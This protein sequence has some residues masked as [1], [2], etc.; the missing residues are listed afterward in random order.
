MA[1][2]ITTP[3]DEASFDIRSFNAELRVLLVGVEDHRRALLTDQLS[4][5]YA[6]CLDSASTLKEALTKLASPQSNYEVVVVN[7]YFDSTIAPHHG[8]AIPL[9]REISH[10]IAPPQVVVYT[11]IQNGGMSETLEAGAFRY[12]HP[13]I[14]P[15]ELLS[16]IREAA[17]YHRLSSAE[18]ERGTSRMRARRGP[19]RRG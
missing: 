9:L 17:E 19:R 15:H 5:Y 2:R 14:E 4:K 11:N 3:D 1:L 18:R 12:L 7:D 8:I 16:Q 6:C 13:P 10:N